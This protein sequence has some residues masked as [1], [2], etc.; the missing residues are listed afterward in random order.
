VSQV[1]MSAM[2]RSRPRFDVLLRLVATLLALASA[3]IL[4]TAALRSDGWA[5]SWLGFPLVG[6]VI[7]NSRP[8]NTTGWLLLA[9]GIAMSTG[10]ITVAT[11]S[12]GTSP[13]LEWLD[14][15]SVAV[16]T[17][18]A[19]L[20]LTFP[21]GGLPSPRWRAALLPVLVVTVSLTMVFAFSKP[22]LIIDEGMVIPNPMHLP[23]LAWMAS[24]E[25]VLSG[26]IGGFILMVIFDLVRR[27]RRS[28]GLERQQ[29]R[30][31]AT[32]ATVSPILLL[33]GVNSPSDVLTIAAFVLALNLIPGAIGVSVLRYR[34]YEIDRL[35]SRTVSYA[36]VAGLLAVVF[37]G[38][39]T[40]LG[41]LVPANSPI[42]VAGSTLTVA[43]L[44]NPM[45]RRV[46]DQVDRWF[47]RTRYRAQQVVDDFTDSIRDETEIGHLTEGLGIVVTETLRP[48]VVGIWVAGKP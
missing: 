32:V 40:T 45:R 16:P 9:I 43:A 18:M 14:W 44:F 7:L 38:A 37:L 12:L 10:M 22:E 11:G 41:S 30:W 29:F 19:M 39:V 8:R 1:I 25:G 3:V 28:Q 23:G 27:Y 26:L 47:N 15:I 36:V 6:A 31:L 13:I 42:A 4:V 2:S 35:I 17:S 24:L 5:L 48:S 20:L 46:R 34:L 33:I 21:G